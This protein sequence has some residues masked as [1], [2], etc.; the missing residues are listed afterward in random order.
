MSERP[1]HGG[2]WRRRGGPLVAASFA[3]ASLLAADADL[4]V[5]PGP[6][7]ISDKE[8]AIE[9]DSSHGVEQAVILAEETEL[10]ENYGTDVERNFHMRAKILSNEGRDLANIEIPLGDREKLTGWWGRTLL[11]DGTVL[12]VAERELVEQPL[13]SAGDWEVRALRVALPGV[14]P[15]SVVDYGYTVK[16]DTRYRYRRVRMQRRWP[17]RRFRY[18]WRPTDA[19]PSAYRVYRSEGFD[20]TI[21]ADRRAVLIDGRNLPPV[22]EE[23]YMPPDHEVRASAVLYYLA[24]GDSYEDFWDEQARE[25][26]A[27]TRSG[28]SGD[29]VK[30]AL[31]SLEAQRGADSLTRLKAAYDW[32]GA[33]V[34]NPLIEGHGASL[35]GALSVASAQD[36][37]DQ[38]FIEI[39]RAL[40]AEAWVV[41]APDRTRHFWDP[42]LRMM[43]QF[44]ARLV[45][46]YPAGQS[47][48]QML[49]V[50]P[51]SGLEFAQV[52]WWV[53][54]VEGMVATSKGARTV[55]LPPSDPAKNIAQT[56]AELAFSGDGSRLLV[57]ST[58]IARGQSGV[59]VA[60]LQSG[61]S[62]AERQDRLDRLCGSGP[63]VRI[64]VADSVIGYPGMVAKLTCES[65]RELLQPVGSFTSYTLGLG[66][67]WL[68][69]LPDLPPGPRVH[70]VVFDFPRVQVLELTVTSPDGFRFESPPDS[71]SLATT[72]GKYQLVFSAAPEG[73]KVQRA[74]ALLPVKVPVEEYDDLRGFL[75]AVRRAD[76]TGLTFT[77]TET[78]R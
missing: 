66:G 50:D 49:V 71:V 63:D 58:R 43:Q 30:A 9:S 25:I 54:G 26:D 8:R 77:R 51:S 22:R 5:R 33:N 78:P 69:S 17:I 74:F 70:P 44:E 37:L 14:V 28:S 64:E 19:H 73:A 59:E 38:L 12:E 31:S 35:R 1:S 36:P 2:R 53:S 57:K 3:C 10:N 6:T 27:R 56:K 39:A 24:H 32:I 62:T 55:F 40:G 15:G 65:E 7:V 52:P 20:V 47:E 45:A 46:V 11:P 61:W 41:L 42:R 75:E 76:A 68:E 34:E 16:G 60:R 23:R 72:Y 21:Q 13:V 67:P 18:R 4:S 48:G 29:L